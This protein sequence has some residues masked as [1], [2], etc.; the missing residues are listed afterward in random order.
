[1]FEDTHSSLAGTVL[2]RANDAD[3]VDDDDDDDG[4]DDD[5]ADDEYHDEDGDGDDDLT[6]HSC[7]CVHV[8]VHA[9]Q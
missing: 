5:D 2:A 8:C 3:D 7:M 4:D 1:M 6:V 9:A